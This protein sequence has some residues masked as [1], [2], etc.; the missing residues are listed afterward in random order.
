MSNKNLSVGII[1]YHHFYNYGTML[2][3]YALQKSIQS[4]GFDAE[5]IDFM[6]SNRMSRMGLIA[7]RFKRL[8]V[9]IT[10]RKKYYALY[11]NRN[12]CE[13]KYKK[14]EKF[15][16]KNMD[17]SSQEYHSTS[18]IENNPPIYDG[19]V[20]GSDQTWNPY[21]NDYPKAFLLSFVDNPK[22]KGSYAPSISVDD[23]TAEQETMFRTYL[24]DL[25]YLSCREANGAQ[26][27]EK[28][29][30]KDVQTVLD[31]T[32]LLTK[33]EWES[34]VDKNHKNEKYILTYFLGENIWQRSFVDKLVKATGYKVIAIP[35]SYLEMDNE[36]IEKEWA[37]PEEFIDLIMNAAYVCTDSFHGTIFSINFNVD[38]YAFCKF[39][40]SDTVSENSRLYCVLN[41]FGL[42]DRLIKEDVDIEPSK[43]DYTYANTVLN[44][45]RNN[46]IEYLRKMIVDIT[47]R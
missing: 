2:Q 37:G 30:G 19:Y 16:I 41:Q 21:V 15:Y 38:F 18:E 14:F 6:Q 22:K 7:L 35:V 1:T 33:D 10:Q 26:L 31:P 39:K 12:N 25:D 46:S 40:D 5:I 4:L 24:S 27:L 13:N 23:L 44:T 32:L 8:G 20:V 34:I 36:K 17:V 11:K 9:Y 42:M 45:E 29:L 43:I 47:A 3:A 28:I